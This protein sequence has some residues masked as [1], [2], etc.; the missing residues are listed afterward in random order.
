MNDTDSHASCGI[1]AIKTKS[2]TRFKCG[3][4]G[5][6]PVRSSIPTSQ[7]EVDM[8]LAGDPLPEARRVV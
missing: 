1:E 8:F 5:P 7:D 3:K 2:P 4:C 6:R